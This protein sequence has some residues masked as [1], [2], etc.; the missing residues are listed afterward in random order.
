MK[1]SC[2]IIMTAK[3]IRRMTKG[4]RANW[5]PVERP[6]LNAGE[7]A[8][9]ISVEVPDSA[10]KPRAL[11]EATVRV[12]ESSLVAAPVEVEI[13]DPPADELPPGDGT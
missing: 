8:V 3:G 1:D 4:R 9:L 6:A 2:W 10:F 12:P 5:T 11:P 13:E 7:Y